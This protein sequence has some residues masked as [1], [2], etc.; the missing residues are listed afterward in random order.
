MKLG[1]VVV[2]HSGGPAM[3]IKRVGKAALG[4]QLMSC[5]WFVQGKKAEGVFD[6]EV[7][8]STTTNG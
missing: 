7:L 8:K 2:L 1:D 6:I 4:R 3:T 5:V